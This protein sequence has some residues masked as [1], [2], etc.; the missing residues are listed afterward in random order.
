ML[1]IKYEKSFKKDFKRIIR[2]GYDGKL[3][4]AVV[5]LLK[6]QTPLPAKYRDH[7]L[8]GNYGN[9]RECHIASDWLLVYCIKEE[10]LILTLTRTGTHS[11]IFG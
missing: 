8:T 3:L 5:H 11:D 2:R 4:D 10:E 7:Q 6:T 9:Y 1:T